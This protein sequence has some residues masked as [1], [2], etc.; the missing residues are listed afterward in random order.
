MRPSGRLTRAAVPMVVC[1]VFVLAPLAVHVAV[2]QTPIRVVPTEVCTC[3]SVAALAEGNPH[4]AGRGPPSANY[5]EQ[6]GM[7]FTQSF[8]SI[9][10]NVTAVEQT[11]PTLGDG[12]AYLVNGL[13]NSGYWYQVGFSWNWAPGS[14]PGT[15]FDMNYEVFDSSGNSVF[16]ADGQG[17]VSAFS[18]PVNEGDNILLDLYFSSG[19]QSVTMLAEDTNTGAVASQ[20]YSSM[21]STYFVGLPG[22]VA[23]SNGY[24]TGLMTE[25][26]HGV[27]YYTNEAEVVYSNPG[28]ALTS[29]WMWVD[30]FD[31]NTLTPVFS[32]NTSA[33]V[34]YVNPAQLQEFSF[35][36]TTEYSDAFNFVTGSLANGTISTGIPLVLSYSLSGGGEGYS[37]PN[38]TYVSNKTVYTVPLTRSPTIYYADP[39][40]RWSVSSTLAG[41]TAQHRWQTRQLTFGVANSSLLEQFTYYSQYQVTFG[42]SVDGGGSGYSAPSVSYVAFGGTMKTPVGTYVWADAGSKY[43]YSS[44]LPGSSGAERWSTL[45]MG[46][47]DQSGQVSAVFYHQYLVT[48]EVTFKDTEVLP[49]LSLSS[50]S[51]GQSYSATITEGTNSE[52]LDYGATYSVTRS[53][54]LE[55]GQ[56]LV[57]DG[58]SDGQVSANATVT[59]V[60]EHQFYVGVA[61]NATD[62]GTTSPS[63]GW[64]DSGSTLNLVAIP[65]QGWMF[66]GWDGTG[67]DSVSATAASV[68]LTVGPGSPANETAIFYPGISIRA[69]GPSSVSYS[70]GPLSGTVAAGTNVVVYAPTSSTLKLT[71]SS[72]PLLTQF[73]GW[74]GSGSGASTSLVVEGPTSIS[75]VSGYDYPGIG[76]LALIVVLAAVVSG[77]V[78]KKRLASRGHSLP[79]DEAA[80]RA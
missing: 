14:T 26:Y 17:G 45:S 68:N 24:F 25:W 35:N 29:A 11:D 20:S 23:D 51:V 53:F 13:S 7:T 33:P 34:S 3:P 65:S 37:P 48:F 73:Y 30:E 61:S 40:T 1:L 62:G 10:Y 57:T 71:G 5:D 44:P 47:V 55:S 21:A 4:I 49:A 67:S 31:A 78:A 19:T 32:A 50:T 80:A 41:S 27:P 36:G 16:P 76:A 79:P 28:S 63:S 66:E 54:S 75:A 43:Q 6:L 18:G 74:S 2:R 77:W 15:G 8:T 42:F 72:I 56:R 60:Y 64:Y 52:W 69:E 22:A 12:P 9:E 58:M 59:L 38:L 70:D 46:Y 39:G